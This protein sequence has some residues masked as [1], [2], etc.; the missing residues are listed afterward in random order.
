MTVSQL[1]EVGK[2]GSSF[3]GHSLSL[4][5]TELIDESSGIHEPRIAF[6][7]SLNNSKMRWPSGNSKMRV[8]SDSKLLKNCG[9][10][11]TAIRR[12]NLVA[13]IDQEGTVRKL[14]DKV[15]TAPNYLS[16][17]KNLERNMG[18]RLARKIESMMALPEGWMD[19]AHDAEAVAAA[20]AD[21]KPQYIIADSPEDLAR[22]LREKGNEDV[23]RVLQLLLASQADI[24]QK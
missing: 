17:I 19:A 13:L 20:P 15:G 8:P 6:C 3:P 7:Y 24:P 5:G 18:N 12:S 1:P 16:E 22:Q 4:F 11:I 23:L 10:D 9:M 2:R 21:G 14:A